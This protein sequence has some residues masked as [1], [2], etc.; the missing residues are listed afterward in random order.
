MKKLV[1]VLLCFISFL[2]AKEFENEII[3]VIT[4][5]NKHGLTFSIQVVCLNNVIFYKYDDTL[6]QIFEKQT[7]HYPYTSIPLSC[8]NYFKQKKEKK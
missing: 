5:I 2:G 1:L 4:P 3:D 7:S 8:E 6:I